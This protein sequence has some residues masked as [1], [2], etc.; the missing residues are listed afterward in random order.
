[1]EGAAA[2]GVALVGVE[3]GGDGDE[4]GTVAAEVIEGAA[5]GGAVVFAGGEGGDGVVKDVAAEVHGAGAGIGGVLVDGKEFHAGLVEEDVL[6]AVAVVNV[7]IED[8]DAF[9]PGGG[10]GE[11]GDGDV[12]QIAEAHGGGAEGVV[13]GGAHEA[14]DGFAGAAGG[15]GIEGGGDG[16][17]GADGDVGKVRGVV[18]E[19]LGFGEAGEHGGG[20]GAEEVG[21]QLT[22]LGGDPVEGEV[23][24][25]LEAGDGG[26]DAGGALGVP[27]LLVAGAGG[28]VNDFH[29]DRRMISKRLGRDKI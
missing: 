14:E 26:D 7:E 29:C 15:E 19:V 6:G 22:G 28:F 16:G 25:F 11:G 21:L 12:V 10:G 5:E 18:V 8:G 27:G 17:A 1:M 2:E 3:A 24:L 23:E 20:V 4:V 13:A 9:G